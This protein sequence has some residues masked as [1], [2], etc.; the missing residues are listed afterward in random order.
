MTPSSSSALPPHIPVPPATPFH[1]LRF[2]RPLS[3]SSRALHLNRSHAISRPLL[4]HYGTCHIRRSVLTFVV[5]DP[6]LAII[7][8]APALDPTPGHDRARVNIPHGYGDGGETCE[9]MWEQS[10][11]HPEEVD[12][13]WGVGG[14][15][16][17]LCA[18]AGHAGLPG[19]KHGDAM[20]ANRLA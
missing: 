18:G 20:Q 2:V 16:G 9:G 17:G 1:P 4:L 5:P 6:Q 11:E 14:G 3:I 10:W 7:V 15:V 8:V 19:S 12:C 13:A